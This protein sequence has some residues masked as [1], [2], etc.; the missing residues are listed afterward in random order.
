MS[1]EL[2][3]GLRNRNPGNIRRSKTRYKGEIES[4]D[5]AFKSF[6]TMAWGYRAMFVLLHT[7]QVRYGIKT[8]RGMISRW[9]P[10]TENPTDNY[11]ASVAHDTGQ[12]PDEQLDTLDGERMQ[13]IVAA[14]SRVE[15]GVAARREEIAEGWRLFRTDF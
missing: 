12:P 7:Y 10:P 11:L 14:M 9:A 4:R 3:R 15:N 5:P 6:R 2:P 1:S 8:L 13:R